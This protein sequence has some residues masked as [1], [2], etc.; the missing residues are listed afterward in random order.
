M[1]DHSGADNQQP[2]T[3]IHDQVI[4]VIRGTGGD[5][6]ALPD[7]GIE[8]VLIGRPDADPRDVFALDV[9]EDW[10]WTYQ[11]YDVQAFR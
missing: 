9:D 1:I 10:G 8:V 11:G 6:F 7:A 3:S 4:N 2:A 5:I